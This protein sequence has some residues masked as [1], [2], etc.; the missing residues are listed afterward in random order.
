MLGHFDPLQESLNNAFKIDN[1]VLCVS[2]IIIP[3]IVGSST[4]IV[5]GL[6]LEDLICGRVFNHILINASPESFAVT[7][8]QSAKSE[9]FCKN[10]SPESIKLS[11]ASVTLYASLNAP[12]CKVISRQFLG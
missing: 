8:F 9:V 2:W 5:C 6:H 7:G 4:D 11:L 1:P 12:I 3:D 10:I